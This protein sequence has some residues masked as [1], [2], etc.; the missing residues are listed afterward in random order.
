[1]PEKYACRV[2]I[3]FFAKR[4]KNACS[5][6]HAEI[7][8][9]SKRQYKTNQRELEFYTHMRIFYTHIRIFLRICVNTDFR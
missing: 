5:Y 4:K 2:R 3:L 7:C 9:F 1:M 8:M 6:T